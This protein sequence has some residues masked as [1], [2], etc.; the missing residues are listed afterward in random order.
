MSGKA[1]TSNLCFPLTRDAKPFRHTSSR[2]RERIL[3]LNYRIQ[4]I[5]HFHINFGQGTDSI[6]K[7]VNLVMKM[8]DEVEEKSH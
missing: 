6:K 8:K 7:Q 2:G 4:Q 5:T 3:R 1:D